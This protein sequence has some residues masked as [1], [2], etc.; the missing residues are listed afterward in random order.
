MQWQVIGHVVVLNWSR[1]TL[2]PINGNATPRGCDDRAKI[3][4]AALSANAV[5]DFKKSGLIAGH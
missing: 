4:D 5:T 1:V 2:I 3:S